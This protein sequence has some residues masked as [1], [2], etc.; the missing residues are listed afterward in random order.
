MLLLVS[1][2]LV[3]LVGTTSLYSCQGIPPAALSR[4]SPR[5]STT[6]RSQAPTITPP[7]Q[8]TD[9]RYHFKR[10]LLTFSLYVLTVRWRYLCPARYV[11]RFIAMWTSGI[12]RCGCKW[13]TGDPSTD[14]RRHVRS[15][16][17]R[18]HFLSTVSTTTSP[19]Q[20]LNDG[21][22]RRCRPR[23]PL[24]PSGW[25]CDART[26]QWQGRFLDRH[27]SGFMPRCFCHP[28]STA[29]LWS[30]ANQD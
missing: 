29:D 4:L 5:S 8:L 19:S 7:R 13:L 20:R 30:P 23:T 2:S 26:K 9:S 10:V 15:R 6:Q 22:K 24:A 11:C 28:F 14:A 3:V 27:I 18:T 17:K 16:I 12:G 1:C 25:T 21:L